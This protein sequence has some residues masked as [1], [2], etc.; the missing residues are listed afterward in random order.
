MHLAFNPC[1]RASKSVSRRLHS[2][3]YARHYT[4]VRLLQ[5]DRK[6]FHALCERNTAIHEAIRYMHSSVASI[7]SPSRLSLIWIFANVPIKSLIAL[8]RA[9]SALRL[10]QSPVPSQ[11][12]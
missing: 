4:E 11:T 8:G 3:V 5:M 2:R 12:V 6:A 9:R 10:P 1:T 7:I